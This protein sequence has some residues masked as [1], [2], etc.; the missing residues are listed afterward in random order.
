MDI[1]GGLTGKVVPLTPDVSHD[2]VTM[3]TIRSTEVEDAS[4][5][6]IFHKVKKILDT[7]DEPPDPSGIGFAFHGAS[8]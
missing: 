4:Q 2:G 6:A 3:I 1:C 7:Q 8:T 5:V